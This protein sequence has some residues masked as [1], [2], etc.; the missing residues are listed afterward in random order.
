MSSRTIYELSCIEFTNKMHTLRII[1][2]KGKNGTQRN[3]FVFFL[4]FFSTSSRIFSVISRIYE[5]AK[6]LRNRTKR[7][8]GVLWGIKGNGLIFLMNVSHTKAGFTRL[9]RVPRVAA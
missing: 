1:I 8:D 9:M 4:T 7:D 3:I 5:F 2:L 6:A